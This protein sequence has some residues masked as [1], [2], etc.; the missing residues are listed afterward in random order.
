[1]RI[2]IQLLTDVCVLLGNNKHFFL[3][4]EGAAH[5]LLKWVNEAPNRSSSAVTLPSFTPAH[6]LWPTSAGL[7]AAVATFFQHIHPHLYTQ[8]HLSFYKPREASTTSCTGPLSFPMILSIISVRPGHNHERNANSTL[9]NRSSQ[10]NGWHHIGSINYLLYSLSWKHSDCIM[11]KTTTKSSSSSWHSNYN[12]FFLLCPY[13]LSS[14]VCCWCFSSSK[15]QLSQTTHFGPQKTFFTAAEEIVES[16]QA[17]N[18]T[19]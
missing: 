9:Q 12:F 3:L 10:T 7:M 14:A 11:N 2:R 8:A 6:L 15:C 13:V 19:N 18:N 16:T 5:L 1:M 4:T 17:G